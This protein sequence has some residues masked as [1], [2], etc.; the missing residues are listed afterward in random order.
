[1]PTSNLLLLTDSYK[2]SHWKQYPPDT[3]HI[4]SHMVARGGWGGF[5]EVVANIGLQYLLR[6]YLEPGFDAPDVE[7]ADELFIEHFGS[8]DVVFNRRGWYNLLE[9]HNGHLPLRIRAVPE[10]TVVPIGHVLL[11]VENTD[12]EFPWLTNYV[13]SLLVQTWYPSTV[14]TQSRAMKRTILKW[15]DETGDPSLIPFKL[16]D[17]GFRGSTSVESSAIGGFA[18]LVNFQG[19]DTVPALEFAYEYY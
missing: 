16:H 13:E 10:G 14:A 8:P 1:M 11:T 7:E 12:P 9:K 6:E 3:R 2:P 4:F 15:L 17:F 5:T 19:T 18:H